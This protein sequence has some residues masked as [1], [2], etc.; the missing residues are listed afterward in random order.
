MKSTEVYGGRKAEVNATKGDV[1][2][3][4]ALFL[5]NSAPINCDVSGI[6]LV[7]RDAARNVDA[8][9][10]GSSL[11]RARATPRSFQR[12]LTVGHPAV[13]RTREGSTPSAG[14]TCP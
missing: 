9:I 3:Q 10:L 13:N 5:E 1:R 4:G 8:P 11:R 7:V 14:A 12:G 2:L 6:A